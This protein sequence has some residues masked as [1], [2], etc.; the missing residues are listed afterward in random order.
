MSCD[1]NRDAYFTAVSGGSNSAAA[2]AFGGPEA[3]KQ[4]LDDLFAIG[5]NGPKPPFEARVAEAQ[6]RLMF[7][8]MQ[9]QRIKPPTHSASGLPRADAQFGYA[10]VQR[11]LTALERGEPLPPQARELFLAR[12]RERQITSLRTDVRGWVRCGRL[13]PVH[14]PDPRPRLQDNRQRGCAQAQPRAPAGRAAL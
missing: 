8:Q 3:A 6:T 12:E 7:A 2:Q 4:A 1:G 10:L 11:T 13:R 9:R 14:Q 5:R